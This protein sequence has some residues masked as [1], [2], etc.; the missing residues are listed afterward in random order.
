MNMQRDHFYFFYAI[1]QVFN[2]SLQF[3]GNFVQFSTI[4][5]SFISLL[6]RF[7]GFLGLE[8]LWAR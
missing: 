7:F 1:L 5:N 2:R 3:L 6:S 8:N 4:Y